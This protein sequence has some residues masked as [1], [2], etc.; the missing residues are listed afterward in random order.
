MNADVILQRGET[1]YDKPDWMRRNVPC[2][3]FFA[4]LFIWILGRGEFVEQL[5]KNQIRQEKSSLPFMSVYNMLF[6]RLKKIVT[7]KMLA[8]KY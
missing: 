3:Y 4:Q 2:T 8:L 1:C 5:I 7:K 6:H